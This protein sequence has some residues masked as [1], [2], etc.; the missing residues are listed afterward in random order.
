MDL[1]EASKAGDADRVKVLLDAGADKEERN[2]VSNGF[3]L[4]TLRPSLPSPFTP[5]PT[6]PDHMDV[7]QQ[8]ALVSFLH[9][10]E[11]SSST[12]T[13]RTGAPLSYW[14]AGR[15]ISRW[16]RPWWPMEQTSTS[17]IKSVH[18]M[19]RKSPIAY[20]NSQIVITS[21]LCLH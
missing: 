10:H 17:R 14:P 9:P 2:A 19:G 3:N 6:T 1:I 21:A 18:V 13:C 12:L 8:D 20:F 16:S 5:S 11:Y 15:A 7:T 4:P